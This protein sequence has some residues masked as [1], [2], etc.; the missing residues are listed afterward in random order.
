M[1]SLIRLCYRFSPPRTPGDALKI[2]GKRSWKKHP[3][4]KN[5]VEFQVLVFSS[6][7]EGTKD[8]ITAPA[9]LREKRNS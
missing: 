7:G 2:H 9:R 3:V 5:G 6:S 1:F 4:R 8:N